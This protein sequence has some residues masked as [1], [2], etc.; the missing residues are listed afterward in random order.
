MMGAACWN[1]SDRT[2][3]RRE[4]LAILERTDRVDLASIY[5]LIREVM[6]P[7][8]ERLVAELV[9]SLSRDGSILLEALPLD[10]GPQSPV[11]AWLR[12]SSIP[13]TA[14]REIPALPAM[15]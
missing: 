12:R 13:A 3:A 14:L 5:S 8:H 15:N 11:V 2:Q 7:G 4:I 9:G 1:E 10:R 6:G